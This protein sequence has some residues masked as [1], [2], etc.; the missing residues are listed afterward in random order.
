MQAEKQHSFS[1]TDD[2]AESWKRELP[3]RDLTGFLLAIYIMRMGRM[4]DD[5]YDRMCRAKFGISGADMRVLFALRR[6]GKPYERR[7][8]DLYR[9]LLVTSG[10]ISKQVDRLSKLGL[11]ERT[12]GSDDSGAVVRMTA[13]GLKN[14]KIAFEALTSDSIV[15]TAIT[16]LSAAQKKSA[17]E[18]C[19][20]MLLILERNKDAMG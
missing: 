5:T 15:A 12:A 6:A 7:S 4:V 8:T 10:A 1:H 14:V 18:L 9:A 19:K 2:I 16:S 11:V 17:Y 13:K 3:D 20:H